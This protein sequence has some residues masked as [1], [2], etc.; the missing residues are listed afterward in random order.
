MF[1]LLSCIFVLLKQEFALNSDCDSGRDSCYVVRIS[2]HQR[3][4]AGVHT[5]KESP[6]FLEIR[7]KLILRKPL[8]QGVQ[9]SSRHLD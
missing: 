2:E 7:D 3:V 6:F 5:R 1:E 8:V 4:D 9:R